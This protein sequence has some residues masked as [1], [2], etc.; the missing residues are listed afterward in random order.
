M[1]D[2]QEKKGLKTSSLRG[3]REEEKDRF[4]RMFNMRDL[5]CEK[6]AIFRQGEKKGK[7]IDASRTRCKVRIVPHCNKPE[8]RRLQAFQREKGEKNGM[9]YNLYSCGKRGSGI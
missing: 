1:R 3:E 6:K 4:F 8:E 2:P 9:L 7:G 5:R